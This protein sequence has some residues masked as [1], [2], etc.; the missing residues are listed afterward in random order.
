M[1]DKKVIHK[2]KVLIPKLRFKEFEQEWKQQE[3]ENSINLISGFP[4]QSEL[5]SEAGTK[6]ITPKNFT[7]TGK[8]YFN[9][10]NTKY[11]TENV[12][13]RYICKSDD[14]LVLLTDLTPT[15]E[16]LGK[17]VL[18][19]DEDGEVLLNQRI[20]KILV[21]ENI[22]N[23]PFLSNLFQTD[24]YHKRIKETSSGTTVRHSSNKIILSYKA[25]LPQPLE[26]QKIASF[27]T[28]V[29]KKMQLLNRKKE[30]LEQYKKGVMQQLFSGKLRFK[31][32]NGKVYPK[33][34]EK[35]LGDVADII[36]GQSPDSK[37]YNA[38]SVGMLLIQGN[39]DISGRVTNP[40]QWTNEPTKKCEI[41]DLILTVRA[42]VGSISKSLHKA[43]IGRGV[44]AI[45]NNKLSTIEYLYQFLLSY[46]DKWKRIEQGS[47]FTAVNGDDIKSLKLNV[48]TIMEQKK[49]AG[50]LSSLD[51]KLEKINNQITQ[52]QIFKKGLLQQMFV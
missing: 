17:P 33:W 11:T 38:D 30:L 7:K 25:T 4:F 45:R 29:D 47:T 34:E 39:A 46:E 44:C 49:I 40:R 51:T 43:C 14:L 12:D 21:D 1:A 16:L 15:C 3:L 37:S 19:S 8:A 31:D 27:L 36:M 26:Q 48:P 6:I 50:F 13:Q 32:E 10:R 20:I 5:F 2:R 18:L 9:E 42:P 28:A 23:K 22:I 35:N 24:T 52:T 41:G